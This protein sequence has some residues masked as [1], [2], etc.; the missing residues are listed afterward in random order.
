[1]ATAV[2]DVALVV[3]AALL[4]PFWPS[5]RRCIRTNSRRSLE[6]FIGIER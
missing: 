5:L 6:R 1:M 3:S 4:V 2:T